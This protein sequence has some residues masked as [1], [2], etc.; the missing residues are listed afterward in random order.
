MRALA[1]LDSP[2]LV[3]WTVALGLLLRV[4]LIA[5][6]SSVPPRAEAHSYHR[7]ATWLLQGESFTP[8]LPPGLPYYL[9]AFYRVFGESYHVGRL[10]ML[11]WYVAFSLLLYRLVGDLVSRRS[12]NL[13]VLAFAL[14]P[15]YVWHSSE[16]LTELPAAT[17]VV[18]AGYV[19][20]SDARRSDWKWLCLLGVVLASLCLI[21]P[22]SILLALLVPP[23]LYLK[24]RKVAFALLPAI[25]CFAPM[26]AWILKAHHMTGRFVPINDAN[27]INF[28]IGNTPY[29]P[30]YKTWWLA[31]HEAGEVGVP[32]EY[33]QLSEEIGRA[34]ADRRNELYGQMA[35]HH[36][37]SHP[38]LF[39]IR[40]LG[41]VRAFLALDTFTGA[42]ARGQFHLGT[43]LSLGLV[44]LDALFYCLV[45]VPAIVFLFVPGMH[46]IGPL[47]SWVL[48]TMALACSMPFWVSISHPTYHL[49]VLPL[50]SVFGAAF[51]DRIPRLPGDLVRTLHA[52]SIR[53]RLAVA[54]ALILFVLV[55]IEWILINLRDV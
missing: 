24:G 54:L 10:C 43:G 26:L 9:T 16:M 44:G 53:R 46:P 20:V 6:L 19:L 40:T 17:C 22:S 41:R 5:G 30:L 32:R 8:R 49:P 2:R 37:A 1:T 31:W 23:F 3:R 29:T 45:M 14:Y 48:L 38:R 13:A 12:A 18:A 42:S 33:T 55:Q 21:R 34:P 15:A 7:M 4:A 52:L 28:F 50:L 47:R 36:I 39:I 25:L 11:L 35:L 27:V 51:M